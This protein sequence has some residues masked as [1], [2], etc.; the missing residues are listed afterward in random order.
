MIRLKYEDRNKLHGIL[1]KLP[2]MGDYENRRQ[3]LISAGLDEVIPQ[4]NL[5][6]SSFVVAS[7]I[8]EI[9]E[10]YGKVTFEHE[11]LGCLINRLKSLI[12][13]D[14]EIQAFLDHLLLDYSMMVPIKTLSKQ[15][16]WKIASSPEDTFEKIIGEN[17]LRHVA[18]L[19]RGLQISKAVAYIEIENK[20]SGTGFMISS[21]FL[22]TNNHVIHNEMFL[23]STTFRFNYQLTFDG[24]PEI[25]K[26]Y[27]AKDN[28]FFYTN[29]DLDYT[30]VELEQ[31]PGNIW[32]FLSLKNNPKIFTNERV[33]IVQHP[34]GMPKQISF[35]N[36]FVAY[37]DS[38]IMQYYTSTMSGSSGS[39]VLNDRWQVVAI[40]HAGGMLSEPKT[41]RKYNR[42]EGVRISAILDD[43]PE[44][45]KQKLE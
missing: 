10:S 8:I 24:N 22:I 35:Q 34:A 17:T 16:S 43:L 3:L 40:H 15:P 37:I 23:P 45:I 6:G 5:Q 14:N 21:K 27:K 44:N 19:Q 29:P 20:W 2:I 38:K 28:G 32:G 7:S 41:M 13:V 1:E 39:P 26:E 4:I 42:N 12:G 11:A 18:F 25:F 9:L 30:I 31:Q 33:N 36:N